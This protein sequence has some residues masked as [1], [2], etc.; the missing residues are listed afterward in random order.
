MK[1]QLRNTFPRTYYWLWMFKKYLKERIFEPRPWKNYYR[2]GYWDSP[3][4]FLYEVKLPDY[5][6][7]FLDIGCA[8]GRNLIPY[9][10]KLR[11]WGID[12]VPE[13]DIQF[14]RN[15]S[16]F[17]YQQK[18]VEQFTKELE[19]GVYDLS[20]TV[21]FIHCVLMYVSKRNQERFLQAARK[22]GC[23]NF[24]IYEYP[25]TSKKHPMEHFKINSPH[26]KV[27]EY[28]GDTGYRY[29]HLEY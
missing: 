21:I 1:T 26:F 14:L 6:D 11:L 27:T 18:T 16:N 29:E 10:G 19:R 7:T 4:A 9:D 22:A 28:P 24:I 25:P 15:F 3:A 23:R 2:I 5:I 13:K 12:I 8:T 17:T 20:K